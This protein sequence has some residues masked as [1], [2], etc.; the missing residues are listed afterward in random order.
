MLNNIFFSF[1]DYYFMLQKYIKEKSLCYITLALLSSLQ[2]VLPMPEL[3]W[4]LCAPMSCESDHILQLLHMGI[5]SAC[6]LLINFC[7]L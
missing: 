3:A 2:N 6:F 4:D 1:H 7:F 5:L